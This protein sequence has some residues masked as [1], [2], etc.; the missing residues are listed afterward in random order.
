MA[1]TSKSGRWLAYSIN[2][3]DDLVIAEADRKLGDHIKTLSVFNKVLNFLFCFAHLQT[4]GITISIMVQNLMAQF[5][6]LPFFPIEVLS[7]AELFRALE[8]AG[9]VGLSIALHTIVV[10]QRSNHAASFLM[11]Q[12]KRF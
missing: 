5:P 11:H 7:I 10:W 1:D 2:S 6:S 12:R 9:E 8:N 4:F 3:M